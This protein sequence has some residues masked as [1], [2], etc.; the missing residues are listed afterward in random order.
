MIL[1]TALFDACEFDTPQS[2]DIDVRIKLAD[3][4]GRISMK[5]NRVVRI[6]YAPPNLTENTPK[7]ALFATL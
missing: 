2:S 3:A 4:V 5:P 7:T 6:L 1:Q